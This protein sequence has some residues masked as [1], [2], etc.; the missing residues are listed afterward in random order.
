MAFLIAIVVC[1][2]IGGLIGR[3]K[4]YP[5]AGFVWGALLGLIGIV[6]V[7]CLHR[8]T[9]PELAGR[10]APRVAAAVAV[11]VDASPPQTQCAYCGTSRPATVRNCEHCGSA[12][13]QV[14]T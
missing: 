2:V 9:G 6:V 8:K 11:P 5:V 14:S 12:Q 4:G 1:S 13:T 10:E 3:A 7:L